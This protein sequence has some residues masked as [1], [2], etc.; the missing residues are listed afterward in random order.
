MKGAGGLPSGKGCPGAKRVPRHCVWVSP[1]DPPSFYPRSPPP[2]LWP[3]FPVS[4]FWA[5]TGAPLI[6]ECHPQAREP[7][8][9]WLSAQPHTRPV[10]VKWR[11]LGQEAWAAQSQKCHPE[12]WKE[13]SQLWLVS[14]RREDSWGWGPGSCPQGQWA[15]F[16][17]PGSLTPRTCLCCS[18]VPSGCNCRSS[19]PPGTAE[20]RAKLGC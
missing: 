16:S 11:W 17:L 4:Q 20:E 5:Q 13:E 2:C 18:L 8:S 9:S 19:E 6:L 1:S 14:W 12:E 10:P 7:V 3:R 15:G